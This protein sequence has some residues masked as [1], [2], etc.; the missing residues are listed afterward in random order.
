MNKLTLL[1]MIFM[2]DVITASWGNMLVYFNNHNL[3]RILKFFC[4]TDK[5][6]FVI[7]ILLI[8]FLYFEIF[9]NIIRVYNNKENLIIN[10]YYFLN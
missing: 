6:N 8:F 5:I 10:F 1:I 2:T 3:T 7:I 4:E 9:I